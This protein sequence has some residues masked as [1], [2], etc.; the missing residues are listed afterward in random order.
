MHV[1]PLGGQ[2]VDA[3]CLVQACTGAHAS[4]EY[5]STGV[6]VHADSVHVRA[7]HEQTKSRE[8]AR[9][10]RRGSV[11]TRTPFCWSCFGRL[12]SAYFSLFSFT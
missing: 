12:V 10:M 7:R 4:H 6:E 9:V 1:T 8:R 5:T 2:G 11:A 3:A